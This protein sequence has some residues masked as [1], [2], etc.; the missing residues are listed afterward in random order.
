MKLKNGTTVPAEFFIHLLGVVCNRGEI[1]KFQVIQEDYNKIRI[2]AV[3]H[4]Q[5]PD[6]YLHD[7]DAKIRVVMGQECEITWN[8]VTE[9]PKTKSGKYRYTISKVI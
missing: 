9:I 4:N 8:F 7:I 5:I 2:D 3:I 1:E 6:D